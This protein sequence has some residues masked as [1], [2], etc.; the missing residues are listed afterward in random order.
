MIGRIII[1]TLIIGI[2]F[3][4]QSCSRD[5]PGQATM[6][7]AWEEFS[8]PQDSNRVKVWWSYDEAGTTREDI[9]AILQGFKR[10]GI[11]G[12]IYYVQ[13]SGVGESY[14]SA[15]SEKC[16]NM[17]RFAVEE[18]EKQG[19]SFEI[20]IPNDYATGGPWITS[21]LGMQRLVATETLVKGMSK[22]KGRLPKPDDKSSFGDVAV[23]A[24]PAH[25]GFYETNQNQKP[26]VSSNLTSLPVGTLF[27]LE[28]KL[29]T[30]PVQEPGKS[31]LVNI[32]FK[33]KYVARSITY[34]TGECKQNERATMNTQG[35]T[36]EESFEQSDLGQL[37]VSD[38]GVIYRKICD[39]KAI[40]R[41]TPATWNQKTISFPA[42]EGR[43]F[44]LN[45]HDWCRIGDEQI[46][47]ILG[48]VL[49]SSQAKPD[50]WEEKV[51][52]YSGYLESDKTP[53][54]SG[55]EVIE[56]AQIV[57]LTSKMGKDGN[58]E[59]DV[60][61][62]EWM[63]LRLGYI[64][65]D[66]CINHSK[67]NMR[68][69]ECDK[70]SPVAAKVQFDNCFRLVLDSLRVAGCS[71]K[72]LT[73]DSREIGLQNWTSGYE[74]EFLQRRGYNILHYLPA[75]V[76]Y[77]VGSTEETNS[78]FYDMRQ[79]I[80]ELVSENYYGTLDSLCRKA[81]VD[82]TIQSS[83]NTLND[84]AVCTAGHHPWLDKNLGNT[85]G[86][87]AYCLNRD[88]AYWEYGKAFW[89]Y[90]ARCVGLMR[91]G[92]SVADLCILIGDS[93]PARLPAYHLPEM[94][95]G[96]DF[97][98][99]TVKTLQ[100]C[101]K[102]RNGRLVLPKGVCCQMLVVQHNE[103]LT[104]ETLRHIVSLVRQGVLLYAS[105]PL[106]S[107][108]LRGASCREEYRKLVD[109]LWGSEI[110]PLGS[111]VCGKGKVYWG[112]SLA[113][114]LAQ[115]DIHA[116]MTFKSDTFKGRICFAHR[117][118]V[119]ADVY[120]LSNHGKEVF[121]DTITLRTEALHAEYWDPI[122]GERLGLPVISG[123]NGLIVK[124]TLQPN[125]TGFIVASNR[126]LQALHKD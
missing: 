7:Q 49:L 57:D 54:Y 67:V 76:G 46:P 103:E 33:K 40:N 90:Q 59:W 123:K 19:L 113:E 69:R 104:L 22:F 108:L 8:S 118:L 5:F 61:K 62:G 77:I 125:E 12:V 43:Y 97:E 72:G 20:N 63:I 39:L 92:L 102:V 100:T 114:A 29:L 117:Q 93:T 73:M 116:D 28:G 85:R 105:R 47:M 25:K 99:T 94:P 48:N 51:G 34:R 17:L 106:Y 58:L 83:V 120:F 60:P 16:W 107:G 75:L 65:A 87:R 82:L 38:D 124:V 71:L 31:V 119:D 101:M 91:K 96:Y 88:T 27:D 98:I 26:E 23:L 13:E 24:F 56:R 81:G 32:D 10:A 89:D 9:V 115:A 37:E 30:V 79:T 14:F 126:K 68:R 64:P 18:A 111:H 11:G 78:F 109:E 112:M 70:L 4:W 41:L 45:L 86:S 1:V 84:F 80:A 2:G 36:I 121:N 95:E 42:V 66:G 35:R 44:R 3:F 110:V 21:G 122:L 55:E 50:Q 15:M 53:E 52:L 74:K 6:K